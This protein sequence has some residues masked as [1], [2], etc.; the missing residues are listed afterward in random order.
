VNKGFELEPQTPEERDRRL[1]ELEAVEEAA[2]FDVLV[3]D[4]RLE[5]QGA[6]FEQV[7]KVNRAG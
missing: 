2:E 7:V 3:E 6:W 1:A 4:R 5:K